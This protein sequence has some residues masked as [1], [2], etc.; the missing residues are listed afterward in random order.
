[1]NFSDPH[2]FQS[3]LYI[4]IDK[5][6]HVSDYYEQYKQDTFKAAHAL[7]D[8]I[9]KRLEAQVV[10]IQDSDVDKLVAN[11]ETI[12]KAQILEDLGHSPKVM[13]HDFNTTR[14]ISDSV[15]YFLERDPQRVETLKTKIN[16]YLQKLNDLSLDDKLIKRVEKTKPVSDTIFS[17]FFLV[18]GFPLFVYGFINNFLPFRIPF[19]CARGISKRPEFQ[20][21]IAYSMG[22][23]TFL[24]F[25]S[26]QIWLASKYLAD[27]RLVLAYGLSLPISGLLAFYYYK[28]YRSIRGSWKIF[29]LFYK[30]TTL[31]TSLITERELIITELEK[32]RK[33]FVIYRDGPNEA[34]TPESI[35]D[36]GI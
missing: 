32:A 18:L 23:F 30:K 36:K 4:N 17:L 35:L 13:A 27:W 6:I 3:D 31:I 7:T 28:R 10:A 33:E 15:H 11:I 22:T 21:S 34:L 1:M 14:A 8:E 20:G 29:S 19:W 24:I 5:P 9:R 16:S 26:L 12:F 2:S 25:Y